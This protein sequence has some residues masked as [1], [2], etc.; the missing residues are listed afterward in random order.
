MVLSAI[1]SLSSQLHGAAG[2]GCA[3]G[4][5]PRIHVVWASRYILQGKK[6]LCS[7]GFCEDE[8]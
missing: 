3:D 7:F 1:S 5:E 2:S 4:D 6:T 8:S